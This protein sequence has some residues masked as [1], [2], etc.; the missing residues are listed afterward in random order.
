MKFVYTPEGAK[1]KSWDFKPEKL[2]NVECE[3]I[4]RRTGFAFG[5]FVDAIGKGSMLAI[6][7]LL[8]VLLKRENPTL[9]WD[10]VQFCLDEIDFEAEDG[11]RAEARTLLEEKA[12]GEGL[13]ELEQL[14]LD[15]L[16]ND[17]IEAG[18]KA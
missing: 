3:A 18:P 2:M 5:D 16:I 13:S 8:W 14:T 7:G 17:D 10:A 4:E 1:P 6:H 15:Q 9:A 11:E 12:A